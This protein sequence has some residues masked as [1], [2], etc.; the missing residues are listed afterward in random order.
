MPS[1]QTGNTTEYTICYL[2]QYG[3][4]EIAINLHHRPQVITDFVGDGSRFDVK[5]T[6]SYEERLLGTAG[7]LKRLEDY[8]ANEEVFL[9]IYGDLLIDQNLKVLMDAQASRAT[10]TLLL[11]QRAGSNSII[12]R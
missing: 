3:F 7:A 10:A 8:F 6:W 1:C 4:D 12:S 9:V 2:A 11:H 5:V